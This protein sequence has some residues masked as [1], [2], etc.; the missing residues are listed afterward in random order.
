MC[1]ALILTWLVLSRTVPFCSHWK[2]QHFFIYRH[3][4]FVFYYFYNG[5]LQT[6]AKSRKDE[7]LSCE[8]NAH[9]KV[10]ACLKCAAAVQSVLASLWMLTLA[11]MLTLVSMLIALHQLHYVT[12]TVFVGRVKC[13]LFHVIFRQIWWCKQYGS[14]SHTSVTAL[15]VLMHTKYLVLVF[16]YLV[17]KCDFGH[18]QSAMWAWCK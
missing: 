1:G 18:P 6:D 3:L 7:N 2:L 11:S 5:A 15:H 10:N 13:P 17:Q 4:F 14:F 12:N 9:H 16:I 8:L